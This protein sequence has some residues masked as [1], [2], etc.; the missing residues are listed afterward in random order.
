MRRRAL[1]A[2]SRAAPHRVRPRRHQSDLLWCCE[3]R[4]PALSTARESRSLGKLVEDV[5]VLVHEVNGYG[6]HI[7]LGDSG[8]RRNCDPWA[9]VAQCRH[10]FAGAVDLG[11][12]ATAVSTIGARPSDSASQRSPCSSLPAP[13]WLARS[14]PASGVSR[15]SFSATSPAFCSK[16][17]IDDAKAP[18]ALLVG[19]WFLSDLNFRFPMLDEPIEHELDHVTLILKCVIE[20]AHG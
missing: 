10:G 6:N 9:V 8:C 17:R 11:C 5:G 15:C 3:P 13:G 12:Y 19:L 7:G 20:R 18:R 2:R 14:V 1:P 4:A 16:R